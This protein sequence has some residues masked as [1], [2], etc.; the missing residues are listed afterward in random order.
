MADDKKIIF[1]M[2][3]VS[4]SFQNN[5][6]VL[7]D[8]YLSFF[9]GA[10]I[11]IIGLNGS[12]KST[13]MKII[14]GLDKNYQGEVVFSPGYSVG[15]L[16]QEPQLDD[17]KTVKEVVMEGVQQVVDTLAEYE[18]INQK[19]GLPEYYEDPEKMDALF[20]RQAELQDIIDATDAWNLD[21]KLERAMDALRCPPEDQ[22]VKNLSG[23]ERRRVALCRLLL[24]KP[25]ILLLDEP[26]NHLDA[27]SIDWLEQHLQQYEGTVIAVTHDRYFLDH[28][29]GWILELDRGE[30]I[31]W[32]GNY[33]SWLEQKTKR[34]EMEEKTAS[35][36][37]KTLERELEWVR[38][39][40]KARQAKGKARLNS[41]DKL[42]NEDV[43]EKEEKLEIFIPNG[44]RL[45]N[46]VIEAKHVAK[47]YGDKLLFDDLNF[48][49]PPN[50]IVG[51]I[52]PN[53]AGKTTLFRLIMGLET[54]DKGEFEVGD[55]VKI[56]YVD[57]QHKDID[58]NKSVYQV[59]SGGNDLIRMGN[60]DVNARAYLSRF[61]FSGSDQEK[62]CGMLS[63]GERNRLHLAM[64]LKEE[65]NVLLLD[66]PTNDIDVNTL[67][68]LEEGLEDFAGCAVVISH[69]RWFL[70]RICTHI[71]AFEGD[72]QVFYFEGSYTEYEENKMK[73]MGNVEPKRV[74]Y[75]KLMED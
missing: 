15:Y 18:E 34:M 2:V 51:V 12:G 41:Y 33:S 60:R 3:G 31:P 74:R 8:I 23:G 21:S 9:Y 49:L 44:P 13:L 58:P 19:F 50:G 14:A 37:R 25:D 72:S 1:S 16:A 39:A 27:E 35:K 62:L 26:T 57:Q 32:K 38:M 70:D 10:K 45:G 61:N 47:A 71:L 42:L 66:E 43:K 7:K 63:G 53:G 28:V 64:A 30:G 20:A 54:V 6:Q 24:Q 11:G 36:R 69:D 68:A 67:R 46:K 4:K 55:T 29:A 52:G 17:A 48:M 40:P 65:G 73:R 22:L 56:A 75:R 5:K 59:I